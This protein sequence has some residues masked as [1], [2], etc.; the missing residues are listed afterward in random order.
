MFLSWPGCL[1]VVQSV[2]SKVYF[3]RPGSG[4]LSYFVGLSFGLSGVIL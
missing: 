1:F 4:F 3:H 2:G